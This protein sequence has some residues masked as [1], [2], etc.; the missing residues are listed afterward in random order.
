MILRP[1]A[2][3]FFCV[4][5]L[6]LSMAAGCSP[7]DP[8]PP[9]GE[10]T[11]IVTLDA[12]P[13]EGAVVV[14]VPAKGRISTGMTDASGRYELRFNLEAKGAIV[15][16]HSVRITTQSEDPERMSPEKLPPK[17]HAESTLTAEVKEGKNDLPFPLTSK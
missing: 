12:K 13:L 11:G 8:L 10:V 16:P 1:G 2:L 5:G 6:A 17:Y 15:G 9:L 3:S 7:K 14:F 4:V